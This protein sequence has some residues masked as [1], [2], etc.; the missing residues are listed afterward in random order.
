MMGFYVADKPYFL[1]EDKS[2]VVD[3][4]SPYA[5]HLL[6]N[7]GGHLPMWVARYYGLISE[8]GVNG[9]AKAIQR[10]PQHKAVLF[11]PE[12]KRKKR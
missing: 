12:N 6:V 7:I 3:A 11:A 4:D 2:R 9:N 1:T 5:A 10:P 8:P